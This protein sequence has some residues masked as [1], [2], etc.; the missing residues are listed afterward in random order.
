LHLLHF[1]IML[2]MIIL[3]MYIMFEV[4]LSC[5]RRDTQQLLQHRN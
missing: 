5:L 4:G 2:P 3:P 1:I